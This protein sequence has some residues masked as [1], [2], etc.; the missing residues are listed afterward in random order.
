[1]CQFSWK[2]R[3][4]DINCNPGFAFINYV[5][6]VKLSNPYEPQYLNLEIGNREIYLFPI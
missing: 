4:R 6:Q 1:M 3:G 2:K 5:I